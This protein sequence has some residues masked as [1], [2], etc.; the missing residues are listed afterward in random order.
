MTSNVA[1]VCDV[2]GEGP[3]L[4]ILHGLFGSARNWQSVARRLARHY[5]VVA[6]DQ[7]NHGR[8]PHTGPF[9][10]AEMAADLT[11]VC[12]QLETDTV[13]LL[14]HS[15]GGKT[16]MTYALA[17]PAR[18]SR[19][20]VVDIAPVAYADSHSALIAALRALPLDRLGRRQD[21]DEAL[22]AAVPDAS[23]RA[24]LLQNLSLGPAGGTWRLNLAALAESMPALVASPP[25]AGHL[26]YGGETHVIRGEQSDR[27]AAE[28]LP[29]FRASFPQL[30]IHT[31]EQAGHWPHAENPSG[32]LRALW[33]AL[34]LGDD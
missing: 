30:R 33:A 14:G 9:G 26:Q 17:Q 19:L 28:H 20:V 11:A 13:T 3:P 7:R 6:V 10:Y 32:F 12:A 27:V 5:R 8:S 29:A 2:F 24:F 23:V 25:G 18:V 4:V 15:M 16:A 34:E 21:A 1:L 31:V 22:A